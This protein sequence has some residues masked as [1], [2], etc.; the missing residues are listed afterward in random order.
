MKFTILED[1]FLDIIT[2]HLV[3]KYEPCPR[4]EKKKYINFT[5]FTPKLPPLGAGPMKF[6]ISCLLT[7]QMLHTK[8][9]EDWLSSS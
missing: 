5:L 2:M 6:T 4:V 3:Y 9:C 1:P 8:F 7:L